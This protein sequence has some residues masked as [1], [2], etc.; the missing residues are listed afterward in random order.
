[1]QLRST[2]LQNN[3]LKQWRF[4]RVKEEEMESQPVL[5][6]MMLADYE[7]VSVKG[8]ENI[9]RCECKL[10]SGYIIPLAFQKLLEGAAA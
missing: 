5:F 4:Y 1:L 10:N 6:S 8:V 7:C 3:W 2:Y 9:T